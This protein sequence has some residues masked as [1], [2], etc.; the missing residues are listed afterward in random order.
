[1]PTL[2][3]NGHQVTVDDNFLKLSREEQDATVDE[4]AK[5]L[6]AQKSQPRPQEVEITTADKIN[7]ALLVFTKPQFY[8]EM[9]FILILLACVARAKRTAR[10]IPTKAGRLGLV[11]HWAALLVAVVLL[12]AAG[13]IVTQAKQVNDTN[14]LVAVVLGVSALVV[15]LVGK[16][17]RY[18]LTGPSGAPQAAV[19]STASPLAPAR[20]TSVPSAGRPTRGPWG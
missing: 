18:I 5:S 6:S 2:T 14:V 4:I 10:S 20:G 8:F 13:L 15:W 19:S 7:G 9:G 3:V 17:L 1:M 16:A 11:L 12:G